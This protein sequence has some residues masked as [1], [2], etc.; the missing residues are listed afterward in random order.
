M[1]R[2]RAGPDPPLLVAKNFPSPSSS[3]PTVP[4]TP[5]TRARSQ[6][7]R[8]VGRDTKFT[9]RVS[10]RPVNRERQVEQEEENHGGCQPSYMASPSCIHV[11]LPLLL[12]FCNN[13][14]DET[15][16]HALR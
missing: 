5:E 8:I 10:R 15:K 3:M 13:K 12:L 16:P 4:S 6:R 7:L 11:A 2:V 14:K 9:F 1:K